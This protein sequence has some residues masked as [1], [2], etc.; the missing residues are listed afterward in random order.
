[1]SGVGWFFAAAIGYAVAV[2]CVLG[3]LIWGG[4]CSANTF[5]G[6]MQDFLRQTELG[7]WKFMFFM[8]LLGIFLLL[9]ALPLLA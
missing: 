1:M 9:W 8:V 2:L 5:I 6:K 3:R 7:F 4:D